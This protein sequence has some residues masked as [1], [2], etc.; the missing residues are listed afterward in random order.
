[1]I[2]N[3]AMSWSLSFIADLAVKNYGKD[4][5]AVDAALCAISKIY[6]MFLLKYCIVGPGYFYSSCAT[7]EEKKKRRRPEYTEYTSYVYRDLSHCG[8]LMR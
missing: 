4:L 7:K 3:V 2:Y 8:V 1:M 5:D 6:L